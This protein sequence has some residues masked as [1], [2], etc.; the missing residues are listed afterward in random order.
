VAFELHY[1]PGRFGDGA[2]GF[3]DRV[4]K[5]ATALR[6]SDATPALGV[7]V[8]EAAAAAKSG[9]SIPTTL[10]WLLSAEGSETRAAF[11]SF[12]Y[13]GRRAGGALTTRA[14]G[15][16]RVLVAMGFPGDGALKAVDAELALLGAACS[17]LARESQGAALIGYDLGD[18]GRFGAEGTVAEQVRAALEVLGDAVLIVLTA[19]DTAA[20]LGELEGFARRPMADLVEFRRAT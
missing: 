1:Y 19:P 11:A 12:D 17:A 18:P 15:R 6:L 16:G 8:V 10:K 13:G 3:L 20:S 9:D 7:G 4:G 14:C 2:E 5:G